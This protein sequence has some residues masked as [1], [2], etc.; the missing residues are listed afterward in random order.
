MKG[1]SYFGI[2][3]GV[4]VTCTIQLAQAQTAADQYSLPAEARLDQPTSS[5]NKTLSTG[6]EQNITLPKAESADLVPS[7][8]KEE[9]S[10][11]NLTGNI[12]SNGAPDAVLSVANLRM[13]SGSWGVK[14]DS[15]G[16]SSGSWGVKSGPWGVSSGSWG[17]KSGPWNVSSGSW[18][19]K[20]G[21]WGVSSGSWG[22][23]SGTYGV[24]SSAWRS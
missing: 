6:I 23:K 18:G 3:F 12:T 5:T 10:P 15:W 4:L 9:N 24:N 1:S 20:S 22:V 2:A 13:N 16:V 17:V 14:P 19:V 8:P 21:S 11:I 7:S